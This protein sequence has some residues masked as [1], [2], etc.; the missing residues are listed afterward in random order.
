MPP[1]VSVSEVSKAYGPAKAVD[2][3]SFTI[4][5]GEFLGFLGPNGAGKTTTIRMMTGII[6]PDRGTIIIDGQPAGAPA[7]T[8]ILGVV[9]ESPGAY[10]WMTAPEYL[11][12]FAT[13]YGLRRSEQ[14]Q[15]IDELLTHVNLGDRRRTRIG[16]YSRGMRQ[17]LALARALVNRPR[18]LVLDEPTL[19]LD[20]QGQE[21]LQGLLRQLNHDGVTIFLSS[22]LL[23]EVASLCSRIAIINRGRLVAAGTLEELRRKTGLREV[24]LVNVAGTLPDLEGLPVQVVHT[25]GAGATLRIEGS[26]NE[27]NHLVDVM[28]KHELI[29][30]EFRPERES[31]TDIF[32]SVTQ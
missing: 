13:L 6:P 2:D 15:R 12:F 26:L 29:I 24:Y 5:A 16:A 23:H 11:Q 3:L 18:L 14:S 31:L 28:R 10:D 27:A 7:V 32:L 17:R 25:H 21:D 22:H 4:E 19:G 30:L 20:P 8:R 1:L 9:P